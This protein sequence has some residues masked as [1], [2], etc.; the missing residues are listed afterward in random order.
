MIDTKTKQQYIPPIDSDG[1]AITDESSRGYVREVIISLITDKCS[2]RAY[3]ELKLVI[4]TN[5]KPFLKVLDP[6]TQQRLQG[7]FGEKISSWFGEEV[8]ICNREDV[9]GH[10]YQAIY[11]T[12]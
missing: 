1:N 9:W 3:P 8:M 6:T 7:K 4:D 11:P 2:H 12:K 10:K 5:D